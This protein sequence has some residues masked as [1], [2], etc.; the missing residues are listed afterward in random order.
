MPEIK[1]DKVE[2][3][4]GKTKQAAAKLSK[5]GIKEAVKIGDSSAALQKQIDNVNKQLT[6]ATEQI[7]TSLNSEIQNGLKKKFLLWRKRRSKT[8]GVKRHIL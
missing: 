8:A 7:K 6:T 4:A 1:L 5:L 2:Q 3:A